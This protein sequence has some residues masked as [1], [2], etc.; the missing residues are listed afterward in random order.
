MDRPSKRPRSAGSNGTRVMGAGEV[1]FQASSRVVGKPRASKRARA[2]S[3]RARSQAGSASR[4]DGRS[5]SK[6]AR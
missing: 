6:W 3:R 1:Y 4:S 2:D 5:L